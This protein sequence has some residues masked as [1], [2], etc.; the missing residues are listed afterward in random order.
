MKQFLF[1]NSDRWTGGH[2][3][4]ASRSVSQTSSVCRH[5][6][7]PVAFLSLA[8]LFIL[9]NSA[10]A[11]VCGNIIREVNYGDGPFEEITP[12]EDCNNPFNA[13]SPAP[14]TATVTL[15]EQPV[16]DNSIITV[17][18]NSPTSLSYA[19]DKNEPGYRQ[20][21]TLDIFHKNKA[22]YK[23]VMESINGDVI[24][25][26]PLVAGEYV[27]VL[28]YSSLNL[29]EATEPVLKAWLKDWLLPATA[30]AFYEDYLQVLVIPFTVVYEEEEAPGASSVLFLPGIQ[31]SRLYTT[32]LF[33][34]ENQLWEPNAN[35][36]VSKLQM[37]VE[38]VS[39]N[40]VYTRD[41]ID[42]ALGLVS[43]YDGFG[44]FLDGLVR[45]DVIAGWQPYAY[46]W[47]YSVFDVLK[48]GTWH[49]DKKGE[50]ER[51]YIQKVLTDLAGESKSG[52]V[53]IVAHSNGG[54]LAKALMI[55]LAENQQ[56]EL[57]DKIILV[58]SP[59]LGTPKAIAS[60][61]HGHG[62][63]IFGGL[64]LDQNLA[65]ETILNLP[66][67]YGLLTNQKYL[68]TVN[69][70]LLLS[71]DDSD[72]TGIFREKYGNAINSELELLY[73]LVGEEGRKT[74]LTL[75]EAGLANIVMTSEAFKYKRDKL[76]P[77]RAPETV[78]V[79]EIVGTGVETES[80]FYY[81][82]F[83][84]RECSKPDA[85][86]TQKCLWVKRYKPTPQLTRYGDGTVVGWSAEGYEGKK[87][88]YYY[89]L[90]KLLESEKEKVKHV[91]LMN[92]TSVQKLISNLLQATSSAVSNISEERPDTGEP[93]HL[94]GVHSPVAIK[95][96]DSQGR[97]TG[98]VEDE[99]RE[100]I[101]HSS[102]R[103]IAD[104]KYITVPTG[105]AYKVVMTGLAEGSY[106]LTIEEINRADGQ[107]LIREVGPA[108]S[109]AGMV[110]EFTCQASG[111]GM[112][113]IDYSGDGVD[114][115]VFDWETGY[116]T[117]GVADSEENVADTPQKSKT[118]GTKVRK[119]TLVKPVGMVA[120]A[121]TDWSAEDRA[122]LYEALLL[123][124][125]ALGKWQ[126]KIGI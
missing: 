5:Y 31:A 49:G 34:T 68:D 56:T 80:G 73:F 103:E 72:T 3:D 97:V 113:R 86:G 119:D 93:V 67:A 65:R 91:N 69:N 78:D 58:G 106:S 7:P 123:L 124:K 82:E 71:F 117:L 85:F 66:G 59:Q 70:R 60:I 89:D 102:Y 120:G 9:A 43:V 122:R 96:V 77:W 114:E 33:G 94:I 100:E 47:R 36:D 64:I 54:L 12:I 87:Q 2:R 22:D 21:K 104:S 126:V 110:A 115:A 44:S 101:P 32:N 17:S 74:A 29:V 109:T 41:V 40:D 50:M 35:V 79:Y 20:N 125:N 116:Q 8:L 76:D 11:S 75:D 42:K 63:E 83:N 99:W 28:T 37:S 88:T 92:G 39:T 38:G 23:Q 16:V 24:V 6:C 55:E 19:I 81:K 26:D 95:I 52:K 107:S 4:E 98:R 27:A 62:Q 25:I 14:F 10:S 90:R 1:V 13:D 108:T 111:C 30:S 61:L 18:S 51:V 48:D 46:D 121:T 84:E 112:I 105:I 57:V 118:S 45:E 15:A 53:T